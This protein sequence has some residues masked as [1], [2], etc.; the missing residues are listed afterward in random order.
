MRPISNSLEINQFLQCRL[1][2]TE[3]QALNK[4]VAEYARLSI[5][6]TDVGI[7]VWCE[8]HNVN[9]IHFDF[10]GRTVPANSDAKMNVG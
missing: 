1:C 3:A 4:P 8:R 9:V 10:Q 7:Q 6:F 5:G 2:T